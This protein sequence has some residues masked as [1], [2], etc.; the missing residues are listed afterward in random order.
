MAS[1]FHVPLYFDAVGTILIA[2]IWGTVPGIAVAVL[3]NMIYSIYSPDSM[4]FA[5]IGV[6]IAVRASTY[7]YGKRRDL[8]GMSLMI[9]DMALATGILGAVLQWIL[10]GKPQFDYVADTARVVAGDNQIYFFISALILSVGLNIVDKSISVILAMLVFKLVPEH[11]LWKLRRTGWKQNPLS[12]DEIRSITSKNGGIS[13]RVKMAFF[14][15]LVAALLSVLLGAVSARINYEQEI[16]DGRAQV[17]DVTKFVASVLDCSNYGSFIEDGQLASGYDN[18]EYQL[19]NYMLTNFKATFRQ[20]AYLYIYQMREDGVYIVFDTDPEFQKEGIIGRRLDYDADYVDLIP[21]LVNGEEI[22]VKEV[23]SSY[24]YFITAYAPMKD[25]EGNNTN[26]FVGAD[27]AMEQYYIYIREYIIRMALS[28]SGFFALILAYGIWT[29]STGLVFPI[30]S[31]G[32]RIEGIV[33][34]IDDQEL[35]DDSVKSLEKIDI[36]TNDEIESLYASLRELA[37]TVAEQMRSIRILAKSNEKMQRGLIVIMADIV[38]NQNMNSKAH[39]QKTSEYCRIILEGLKRKG[40]YCEKLTDKYINDVEITS[41]LYDIGKIKVP[42][43]IINKPGPLTEE[44]NEIMKT[45]ALAGKEILDNAINIVEGESYLKE[46]RNMAAYHHENWDGTG[47]P[48]GLHGEVIPLSARVMA[49]A[50][51]FDEI[52]S[53]RV[54][55]K[56]VSLTEALEMIKEGSGTKYDPKCVEVFEDNFTEVKNIF[57]KYPEDDL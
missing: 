4:C 38:S 30:G 39:I 14:L 24:G 9:L 54:Y 29:S 26:F 46:A 51:Y 40:Y 57:R 50:D 56:P 13:I 22:D 44:E 18:E 48:L 41:P 49:I 43:A 6:I 8:G 53:P 1:V 16:E 28:F 35:L 15:T 23:E 25:R 45:H 32:N 2:F 36:H 19:N 17:E 27:I 10:L 33:K 42:E 31:L 52:T 21:K 20:I 34:G 11:V 37:N 5:L 47:Y 55:R 12:L 7:T 3:T